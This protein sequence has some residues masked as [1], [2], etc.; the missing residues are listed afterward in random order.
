MK[1]VN[2]LKEVLSEGNTNYDNIAVRS[3]D[4]HWKDRASNKTS[5]GYYPGVYFY[6]GPGAEEKVKG[7]FNKYKNIYKLD[8]TGAKLYNIESPEK[9]EKLKD[10]AYRASK[11]SGYDFIV[12]SGSGYGDV[13]YLKMKGYD[14][15][16]RGIEVIIFEPEKFKEI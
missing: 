15:I 2:I 5:S 16:R 8:I 7:N 12:T 11:E 1:I 9:A 3:S 4:H 13:Q 10:E 14:G 6:T